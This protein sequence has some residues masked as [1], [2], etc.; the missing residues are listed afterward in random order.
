MKKIVLTACLVMGATACDTSNEL[1]GG[2]KIPD[3]TVCKG[4]LKDPVSIRGGMIHWHFSIEKPTQDFTPGGKVIA[5]FL[6]NEDDVVYETSIDGD[7]LVQS[8]NSGIYH[9]KDADAKDTDSIANL[10]LGVSRNRVAVWIDAYASDLPEGTSDKTIAFQIGDQ[11][12]SLHNTNWRKG[13]NGWSMGNVGDIDDSFCMPLKPLVDD[14]ATIRFGE[15]FDTFSLGAG[16]P[17][18][19]VDLSTRETVTVKVMNSKGVIYQVDVPTKDITKTVNVRGRA[20]YRYVNR[21]ADKEG[22]IAYLRIEPHGR[23]M[24]FIRLK[25]YGDL[26]K[27]DDPNMRVEVTLGRVRYFSEDTFKEILNRAGD[28]L[29]YRLGHFNTSIREAR[30]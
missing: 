20:L 19:S 15:P 5:M 26:S 17:D 13:P 28:L 30:E 3:A 2:P 1:A 16:V 22:G 29:G 14:P 10:K 18:T 23:R 11:N 12:F 7:E 4:I 21:N 6:K 8:G 24:D 27:A 9:Y 25:S